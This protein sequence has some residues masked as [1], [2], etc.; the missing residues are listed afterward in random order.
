MA[1]ERLCDRC[2]SAPA[3]VAVLKKEAGME[4]ELF[5]CQSCAA[6]EKPVP[7]QPPAI[8]EKVLQSIL[9]Q[10]S[11][12]ERRERH[13]M[14]CPNCQ[15]TLQDFEKFGLLGCSE[16]YE[17]FADELAV[18]LKRIHGS[19]KHIGSRPRPDRVV[20]ISADLDALKKELH[21]SIAGEDFERAAECRDLIR[22][23][24][25]EQQRN[26]KPT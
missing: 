22:D 11:E 13:A 17:M 3:T 20:S 2:H 9:G 4:Q 26:A 25:R 1:S 16:C 21:Q 7:K 5:L 24:E 18:L 19:A 12:T 23:L 15:L 10:E 8:F 6:A 14:Q